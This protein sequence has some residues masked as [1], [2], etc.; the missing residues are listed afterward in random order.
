MQKRHANG[1]FIRFHCWKGSE[2]V[3]STALGCEYEERRL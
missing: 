2:F 1:R 3:L